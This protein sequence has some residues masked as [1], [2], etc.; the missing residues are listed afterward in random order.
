MTSPNF[1]RLIHH[2]RRL[3]IVAEPR[4][5]GW[6][7]QNPHAEA[8]ILL[9]H[10][11]VLEDKAVQQLLNFASVH[12]SACACATPDFHPGTHAPVGSIVATDPSVVIPRAI[13]TDI[14]CGMR[15]LRTGLTL[16]SI[17]GRHD[18]LQSSM[19]KVLLENH[20]NLPLRTQDFL[21]LYGESPQAFISDWAHREGQWAGLD[22]RS[23]DGHARKRKS[24]CGSASGGIRIG[25]KTGLGG[26][27][28]TW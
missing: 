25:S 5:Y 22:S 10:D 15:T 17:A 11:F 24:F 6:H 1:S 16:A 19:S 8:N 7:V 23:A 28:T 12:P 2:F 14:N 4:P 26:R 20:R 13:G 3:G 18:A 27:T 21:R 9:P